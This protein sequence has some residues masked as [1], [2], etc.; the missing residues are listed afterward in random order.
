MTQLIIKLFMPKGA[1][2]E[3]PEV[4]RRCGVLSGGIGI[5]LNLV[6]SFSKLLAGLITGSV[7][8]VADGLNNLSDAA[9]SVI[10]LVGFRL[11]GQQADQE[12][13]FGHGRMEYV[14]GLIVALAVLLMGF[15]VGRSAVEQIVA[16]EAVVFSWVAC[17]VLLGA[18][19][20]KLWM[21][22]FNR[23]LGRY[24]QSAALEATAADS[25]SDT[26]STGVV[27]LSAVVGRFLNVQIDGAAGLLVAIF[28][29][30]TG[31]TAA[32][33]T[34]DPILGRPMDPKLAEDVDQLA[35]RY[36][37]ILGIHDLVYHDYGPGRAM[38]SFHAEVPADGDMLELHDIID[39]IE[40]DLERKHHIK[41]VIHM[42]PIVNDQHTQELK[43]QVLQLAQEIDP[44]ITIH[45]FRTTQGPLLTN[46]IFDMV[47]PYH[48]RMTDRETA[49]EIDR[50]V[51]ERLGERYYTVATVERS[52]VWSGE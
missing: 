18:I 30:K 45:D 17:G 27:L 8:M 35:R 32:K 52:Y 43:A 13:P 20:V 12:H 19:L 51:K 50:L 15:E 1:R 42:D 31:W 6:L 36:D 28:I 39:T 22:F 5:G 47:V 14:T 24:I 9:T 48:F 37:H 23:G 10:T 25:L 46:L 34:L 49:A 7:A 16:P 3:D 44:S 38:M 26:L 21:F 4:R 41:T 40:R 2:P 33:E 29:L 11:A